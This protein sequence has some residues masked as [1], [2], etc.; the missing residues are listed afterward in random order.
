MGPMNLLAC[1]L[2]RPII[3]H[4]RRQESYNSLRS[5]PILW[6]QVI[7]LE[8][9]R[10]TMVHQGKIRNQ[11]TNLSID[12][13]LQTNGT[14]S[15]HFCFVVKIVSKSN[16]REGNQDRLSGRHSRL[17]QGFEGLQNITVRFDLLDNFDCGMLFIS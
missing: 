6:L 13:E 11:I 1:Q 17:L 16:E 12:Y 10:V 4:R 7:A 3:F 9:T 8:D 15:W 14:F 5:F 2:S